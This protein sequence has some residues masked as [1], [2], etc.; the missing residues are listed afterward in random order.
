MIY[1][2]SKKKLNIPSLE[3]D[4]LLNSPMIKGL[5]PELQ[6]E[7]LKMGTV[8]TLKKGGLL[9]MA[10]DDIDGVYFLISGKLKE[11]Y[12]TEA[13]EICLRRILSP[14]AHVSLHSVLTREKVYTYTCEV[15]RKATYFAWPSVRFLALISGDAA[16]AIKIGRASC[17]ERVLRL[18]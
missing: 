10:G 7:L 18:V 8:K 3:Y 14:G 15:I 16:L 5:T 4:F 17:R 9:F 6:D 13:G 11:Y 1:T 12:T 2:K